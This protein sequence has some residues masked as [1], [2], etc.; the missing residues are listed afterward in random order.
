[1][2]GGAQ[3]PLSGV[4]NSAQQAVYQFGLG[5]VV[6]LGTFGQVPMAS[7]NSMLAKRTSSKY[8]GC[9]SSS[10]LKDACNLRSCKN[11]RG[12]VLLLQ[13][14]EKAL[15]CGDPFCTILDV[16]DSVLIRLWRWWG[17]NAEVP[18]PE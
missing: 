10:T 9:V 18:L 14:R 12:K 2:P 13:T 5:I 3:T 1:V 6:W 4:F 17:W 7:G 8:M 16:I 15:L 11:Y